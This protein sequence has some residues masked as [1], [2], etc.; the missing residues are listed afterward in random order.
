MWVKAMADQYPPVPMANTGLRLT[1]VS[2]S[3]MEASGRPF[4]KTTM[5]LSVSVACNLTWY[6]CLSHFERLPL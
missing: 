5:A 4:L 3:C 6:S 1:R 2:I